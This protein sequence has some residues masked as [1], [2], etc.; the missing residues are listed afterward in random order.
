MIEQDPIREQRR[1]EEQYSKMNDFHLLHLLDRSGDLTELARFVLNQEL[2]ERGLEKEIEFLKKV[3]EKTQE[4]TPETQY[5][6]SQGETPAE[7]FID[8]T[9]QDF[10]FSGWLAVSQ[11]NYFEQAESIY[12][13]VKEAGMDC[14]LTVSDNVHKVEE[15]EQWP[16]L[17]KVCIK[18][19]DKEEF[20]KLYDLQKSSELQYIDGTDYPQTRCPKCSFLK[21]T[22]GPIHN[23]PDKL[24]G[25]SWPE[26]S[27]GHHWTCLACEHQW[28][29]TIL[30]Y[31]WGESKLH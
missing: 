14:V 24:D 28:Q 1:L 2:G 16:G 23:Q 25:I 15:M 20:Y 22:Y 30:E 19:S 7:G 3:N 17:I 5:I 26:F 8:V 4:R 10:D 6:Q 27:D 12:R 29:D 13:M 11:M 21:V 9:S 18:E 31:Y